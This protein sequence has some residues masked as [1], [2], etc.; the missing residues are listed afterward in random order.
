MANDI[1]EDNMEHKILA[2]KGPVGSVV[3]IPDGVV[4]AGVIYPPN[5]T[6]V[7]IICL[8]PVAGNPLAA[9]EEEKTPGDKS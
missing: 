9:D 8:E 2:Y 7:F 4:V 5:S 3:D 1:K 6:D